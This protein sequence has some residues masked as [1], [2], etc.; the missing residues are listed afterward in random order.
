RVHGPVPG[1]E[2]LGG[3]RLPGDLLDVRV[4]VL[5]AHVSPAAP[6]PVRQQLRIV[7]L[8]PLQRSDDAGDLRIGDLLTPAL[9]ALGPEV[10]A[11]EVPR[12]PHVVAPDR[13][14]TEGP[15]RLRV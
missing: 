10:E 2:V 3:E 15:V 9:S 6:V 13:R 8:A 11:D 5:R 7:V 4:H 14:E 1:P 12:G